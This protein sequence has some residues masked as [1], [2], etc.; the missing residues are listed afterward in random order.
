MKINKRKYLINFSTRFLVLTIFILLLLIIN[1]YNH[2][3]T[4]NIKNSLF[5]KSFNFI[6]INKI[7]QKVLG[8]DVFY[9][10]DNN[11][12]S[13]EV[14]ANNYDTS[15][16]EKYLDAEKLIVSDNLPIGSISSGVV[17]YIGNKEN[18]GNTVIIQGI[19]GFNIW[20]GN[21]KDINVKNYDYIEKQSLIG[22]ADGDYIYLLIE[23]NNK[24]YSYD[25]Y[26][27][28]KD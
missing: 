21:I 25:E 27:Q 1:K 10:Q 11:N 24:Y 9:Y 22:A 5:D 28:N 15:N 7:S 26:V 13:I 17:V 4:L 8:K 3:F 18:Y 19:D 20:Y 6:K 16:N 2:S 23:K 12:D 14:L